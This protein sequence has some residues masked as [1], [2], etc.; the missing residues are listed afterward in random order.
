MGRL[1]DRGEHVK[2][3]QFSE[4]VASRTAGPKV[5]IDPSY[6]AGFTLNK[7][8]LTETQ[9][10]LVRNAIGYFDTR[11]DSVGYLERAAAYRAGTPIRTEDHND[12]EL[13]VWFGGENPLKH[14]EVFT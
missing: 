11:D 2:S 4:Y 8:E 1:G 12:I 10:W 5:A 6:E 7:L 14:H 13:G 3:T 9:R